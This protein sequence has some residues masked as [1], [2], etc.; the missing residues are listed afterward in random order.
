MGSR[1]RKRQSELGSRSLAQ[2][3]SDSGWGGGRQDGPTET[4]GGLLG[5]SA[6]RFHG[7]HGAGPPTPPNPLV[8]CAKKRT[9]IS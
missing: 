3:S 7:G 2:L 8:A 6:S 5:L 1:P 4:R 9:P